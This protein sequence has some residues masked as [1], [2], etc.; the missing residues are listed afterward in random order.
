MAVATRMRS[1]VELVETLAL[2]FVAGYALQVALDVRRFFAF[3][4]LG[5]LL[6]ELATTKLGQ[7]SG[8]FTGTLEAPQGSVKI[9][10][11]FYANTWHCSGIP[12]K[13]K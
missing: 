1:S 5:G 12:S 11:L 13:H 7:D 6:V 3:S 8:L 9:L 4:F 10:V 2:G